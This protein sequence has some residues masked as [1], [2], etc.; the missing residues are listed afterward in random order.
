[1]APDDI[2]PPPAFFQGSPAGSQ[3]K[4]SR[5]ATSSPQPMLAPILA[6]ETQG[7]RGAAS[8]FISRQRGTRISEEPAGLAT[9]PDRPLWSPQVWPSPLVPEALRLRPTALGPLGFLLRPGLGTASHRPTCHRLAGDPSPQET[10]PL[11]TCSA[12]ARRNL[13]PAPLSS[14]SPSPLAILSLWF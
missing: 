12:C 11:A 5:P 13:S 3:V 9:Q 14:N 10:E 2:P 8:F 7:P 6:T 1:M 4:R